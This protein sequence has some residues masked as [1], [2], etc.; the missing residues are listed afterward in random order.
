[1]KQINEA[2]QQIMVLEQQKEALLYKMAKGYSFSIRKTVLINVMILPLCL[3][4]CLAGVLK[5]L[6]AIKQ[7]S[8]ERMYE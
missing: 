3:V 1:M 5:L 4:I 7:K 8:K 6:A 2:G